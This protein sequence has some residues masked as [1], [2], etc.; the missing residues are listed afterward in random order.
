MA[1]VGGGGL[2]VEG[3]SPLLL[4]FHPPTPEPFI[5]A[6]GLTL[7]CLCSCPPHPR[8]PTYVRFWFFR[9]CRSQPEDPGAASPL[10]GSRCT[11]C[12][13]G[14]D[15]S[16][17]HGCWAP[18]WSCSRSLDGSR[19]REAGRGVGRSPQAGCGFTETRQPHG[20]WQ[21]RSASLSRSPW[22]S[23]VSILAIDGLARP[24]RE[25]CK[26]ARSRH[27][28]FILFSPGRPQKDL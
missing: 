26:E 25:S 10:G 13:S 22:G 7:A 8:C 9:T 17:P 2:A 6:V 11:S 16:P 19:L 4:G 1:G 3:K 18:S 28:G 24:A 5:P 12:W 14:P 15:P 20:P 23:P 27:W 21:A